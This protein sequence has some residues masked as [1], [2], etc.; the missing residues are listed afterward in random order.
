MNIVTDVS[1]FSLSYFASKW[2]LIANRK[3]NTDDDDDDNDDANEADELEVKAEKTRN[4][5][6]KSEDRL[7]HA[8]QNGLCNQHVNA[9]T[10]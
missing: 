3:I 7:L 10:Q 9:R 6:L 8:L 2:V 4:T 5:Q 1:C